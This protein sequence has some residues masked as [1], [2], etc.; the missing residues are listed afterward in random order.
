MTLKKSSIILTIFLFILMV[1]FSA[2]TSL[3]NVQVKEVVPGSMDIILL[4][5]SPTIPKY[6]LSLKGDKL[7]INLEKVSNSLK[8]KSVDIN[9][10]YLTKIDILEDK[11]KE[12]TTLV[13]NFVGSIPKYVVSPKLGSLTL[14]FNP[15]TAQTQVQEKPISETKEVVNLIGVSL[16][17]NYKPPLIVL[18]T[19]NNIIPTYK[20][21]LLKNPLRFVV[22][23]ENTVDKTTMKKLDINVSPFIA[24]RISQFSKEPLVTRLVFDLKVSYPPVNVK[25]SDRGLVVGTEEVLAKIPSKQ[26]AVV[27][28][29]TTE[30][31]VEK[32]KVSTEAPVVSTPTLVTPQVV[33]KKEE[34]VQD[35]FLQKVTLSFDRAEIRDVLKAMGQLVGMNIITDIS[36]QGRISVYLKDVTFRDAF[37]SLLSAS[38]LGYIQH[39]DVLIVSTLDKMQKLQS[40]DITTKIF[41]F[42]YFDVNKAKEIVSNINKN[43]IVVTEENRKWLIVSGPSSELAKIESFIKSLD[44]PAPQIITEAP[45]PTD[46]FIIEKVDGKVYLSTNLKGE[47]IKDVLQE[48]A[49]KTGKSIFIDKEVTGNVYVTLNRVPLDRA[50]DLIIRGSGLSYQIKEG[51][52]LVVT[53]KREDSALITSTIELLKAEVINNK[54]YISGDLRK[55]DI[56]DVLKELSTK[57]GLNFVIDP[58]VSGEVEFYVNQVPIDELLSLLGKITGF[59]IEKVGDINYIKPEE[60]IQIS[61]EVAKTKLYT[62]RYITLSDLQRVGGQIVKGITFS[63]DE[64]TGLLVA[65]GKEEDLKVLED[66]ISKVDVPKK[67]EV[68]SRE[69]LT[70][71]KEGDRYLVSG[72]L[73]GVDIKDI[74]REIGRK[75]GINFVIDPRVSGQVELY[76]NKVDLKEVMKILSDV[77]GISIEESDKVTYVKPK[78][79]EKVAVPGEIAKTKLYTLRYITLSDLQRVGGQI[80]KGI[81]FSFDEKTGLLVATGKEEDLKVLE[82]LISKVD[83]PKKEE[84]VSRE[85]LTIEK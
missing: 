75:T 70:I 32:P 5:S 50:I 42:E 56:R 41:T 35:K 59:T 73:K 74:I 79:E 6:T 57:T 45:L 68:V 28:K 23:L 83:V 24:L 63:F 12:V 43:L 55:V 78:T 17:K 26:L 29:V 38:D 37:Y 52:E 39:G 64:K 3:V 19:E 44:V 10:G 60:K 13:I 46:K 76:L 22:D 67:E 30:T 65:T 72:E 54:I 9:K 81:T 2:I 7:Y 62:L 16:D 34:T 1:S 84:V 82:D 36:V 40:K 31:T 33:Q 14:S 21:L 4:F 69:L 80:V 51:G 53:R 20:T 58:K 25:I 77:G 15:T 18:K 11:K 8:S 47:D 27:T 61:T 85:L 49:R 71:E 66:L 48:I